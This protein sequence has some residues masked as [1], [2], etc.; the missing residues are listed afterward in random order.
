MGA[1][2][3]Q[4]WQCLSPH[5]HLSA[6]EYPL[7]LL[8]SP[9]APV[10][11]RP[12][13]VGAHH[14]LQVIT[15]SAPPL[16][17]F[18]TASSVPVSHHHCVPSATMSL[19]SLHSLSYLRLP[20]HSVTMLPLPLS[21]VT[22]SP[23]SLC[24]LCYGVP[25]ITV[26]SVTSPL[27]LC[28]LSP[29]PFYH[30]ILTCPVSMFPLTTFHHHIFSAMSPVIVLLCH[31]PSCHYLPLSPCFFCHH[32]TCHCIPLVSPLCHHISSVNVSLCHSGGSPWECLSF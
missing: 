7:Q 2:Q 5:H 13:A 19:L 28:P 8:H 30:C 24:S 22:A 10:V 20:C 21:N 17:L 1:G 27:S 16:S 9:P 3:G 15:T 4:P 26:S 6:V 12:G 14:S 23:L 32:I 31:C 29:C 25:S 11:K 18:V